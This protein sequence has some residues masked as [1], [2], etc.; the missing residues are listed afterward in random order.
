MSKNPV[1]KLRLKVVFAQRFHICSDDIFWLLKVIGG[2]IADKVQRYVTQELLH[3]EP[4]MTKN[5]LRDV[6]PYLCLAT[7]PH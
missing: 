4:N 5:N 1:I 7:K 2:L 6:C 3:I